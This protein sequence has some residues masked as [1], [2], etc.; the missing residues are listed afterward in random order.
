VIFLRGMPAIGAHR[1]P[2]MTPNEPSAECG[3]KP[4]T[5]PDYHR[6]KSITIK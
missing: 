6:N 2:G 5:D 3:G 4:E 1:G